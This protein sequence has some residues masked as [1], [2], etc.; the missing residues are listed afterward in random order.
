[1]GEYAMYEGSE[2][3]IGT[4]ESLYYLRADQA[5]LISGYD[6]GSEQARKYFRYRFPFPDEDQIEPGAFDKYDRGFRV[7]G[8]REV[9][10]MAEHDTIQFKASGGYLVSLPCPEQD[11]EDGFDASKGTVTLGDGSTHPYRVGRNGFAGALFVQQQ[12][13]WDGALVTVMACACGA[14]WRLETL[15]QAEPVIVALRSMAD[16]EERRDSK[17][18]ARFLHTVAD[19]ITAGYEMTPDAPVSFAAVRQLAAV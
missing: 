6:L 2:I 18:L 1:M 5:H 3:K 7:D 19:R 12:R 16:L 10:K 9:L 8:A 17:T 11:S 4:C 13:W 14:L 15:A